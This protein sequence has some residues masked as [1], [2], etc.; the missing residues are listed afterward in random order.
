MDELFRAIQVLCNA[1]GV[2]GVS[3]FPEKK[4]YKG[5]RFNV[6]TGTRRWVGVN[7]PE[8]SFT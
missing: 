4:H 6:F 1:T 3:N 2:G 5:V 7:F 8:K